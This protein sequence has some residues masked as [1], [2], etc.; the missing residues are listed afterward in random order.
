MLKTTKSS[1]SALRLGANDNE[2]V[3]GGGK[4]DDKNL[5]KSKMSKNAKS[6]KQTHIE[7]MGESIFLTLGTRE[8]FNQLK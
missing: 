6:G 5:S 1:D 4:V 3:G 8:V 2:V 7:L